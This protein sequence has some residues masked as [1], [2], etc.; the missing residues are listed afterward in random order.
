MN[1]IIEKYV[2]QIHSSTIPSG[3]YA[4]RGHASH[5]WCLA[6]GATRRFINNFGKGIF[7]NAGYIQDYVQYHKEI[8]R[9][10]YNR[11]FGIE[12]GRTIS[13]LQ[14]LAKM[15]H[16]GAATCLL[17]FTWNPLIALWFACQNPEEDGALFSINVYNPTE[18]G[19]ISDKESQQSVDTVFY[20]QENSPGLSYWEPMA[21]GDAHFR[22]LR[23]RSVFITGPSLTGSSCSLGFQKIPIPKDDKESILVNLE[24]LDVGA[25]SL[26]YDIFG[27]SEIESQSN[28]LSRPIAASFFHREGNRYF[29]DSEYASAIEF[30]SKAIE[31]AEDSVLS[32]D[33]LCELY[34]SRGNANSE[35]HNYDEAISDYNNAISLRENTPIA[36]MMYFNRA[37]ANAAAGR[38][39][40]AVEDFTKSLS[41]NTQQP[42]GYYN[43]ANANSAIGNYE[44]ALTDYETAIEL[45]YGNAYFNM[46]STLV[47]SGK[48][49]EAY[50]AYQEAENRGINNEAITNNC[51]HLNFI[52]SKIRDDKHEITQN[53]PESSTVS[54][55]VTVRIHGYSDKIGGLVFTGEIGNTGNYGAINLPG[56]EG[57]WGGTGFVVYLTEA[58]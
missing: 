41:R 19:H 1:R 22:I 56:G 25:K 23:Q 7:L 44:E 13:E 51:S 12:H 14:L 2:D 53:H 57:H 54:R 35:N 18:V 50:Q 10:A 52:L 26:F 16:F 40:A 20:R 29:Q 6:D 39:K 48:F 58:K 30:Y 4:Y 45:G 42:S 32:D 47:L 27:L 24:F 9:E 3:K 37:N 15:Q 34:F 31:S 21:S 55:S 33:E 49:E 38:Y 11:G 5:K 17:D 8:L 43:R 46:A 28:S 36:Y